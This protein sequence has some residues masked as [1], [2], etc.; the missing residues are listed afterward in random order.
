MR[1]TPGGR[2]LV[3][4][5]AMEGVTGA[6]ERRDGAFGDYTQAPGDEQPGRRREFGM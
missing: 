2:E 1:N 4:I 6:V 5:A 3:H